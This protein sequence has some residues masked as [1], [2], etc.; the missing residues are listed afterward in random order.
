MCKQLAPQLAGLVGC[1]ATTRIASGEIPAL[2]IDCGGGVPNRIEYRGKGILGNQPLID[3]AQRRYNYLAILSHAPHPNAA[4]LFILYLL[5]AE[6]Q[7]KMM[8]DVQGGDLDDFPESRMRKEFQAIEAQGAK[9][10]ER[11][12]RTGGA[13]IPGSTRRMRSWRSS[14][15]RSDARVSL[16][17]SPPRKR[18]SRA[19][20]RC[21][22]DSRLSSIEARE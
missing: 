17:S 9:P 3:M 21:G 10:V 20:A 2:A 8:W 6:G 14:C 18:E 5:T 4:T 13:R 12:H 11:H 22:P 16:C 7:G 1:E 19:T 15:A